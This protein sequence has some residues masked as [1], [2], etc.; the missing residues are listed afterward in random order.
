MGGRSGGLTAGDRG[1]MNPGDATFKGE[2]KNIESL[3]NIKDPQ[4]YKEVKAAI[5]RFAK[6]FGIYYKT[7]SYYLEYSA[8]E[9]FT[10]F[11][12]GTLGSFSNL[13]F[14]EATK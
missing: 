7:D 3:K 11:F 5:S 6:E 2:I 12:M 8:S 9:T 14:R 10:P 4:L 1:G 13:I